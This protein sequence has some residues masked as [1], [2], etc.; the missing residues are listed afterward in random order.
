MAHPL[1]TSAR[2][3][4][5][6]RCAQLAKV[7]E[8]LRKCEKAWF[9]KKNIDS[10]QA[11]YLGL[12][13]FPLAVNILIQPP[14]EGE[15]YTGPWLGRLLVPAVSLL[16]LSLEQSPFSLPQPKCSLGIFSYLP[17][18]TEVL[19]FNSVLFSI[20]PPPTPRLLCGY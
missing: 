20:C 19:E 2:V 4:A 5:S 15:F 17:S 7:T 11:G 9:H 6:S 13:D 14:R 1:G 18:F 3:G 16:I 10:S 12:E 8:K